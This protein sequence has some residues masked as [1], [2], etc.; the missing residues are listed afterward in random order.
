MGEIAEARVELELLEKQ[1]QQ[2]VDQ[3]HHVRTAVQK[4]KMKLEQLV[5]KISPP[6][7]RLPAEILLLIFKLSVHSSVLGLTAVS[8][9]WRSMVLQCP[10]LWS[11]IEVTPSWCQSFV[12]L[13]VTRSSEYPL[14]IDIHE[15]KEGESHRRLLAML[16][17]LV[18]CADHWRSLVIR[19][20]VSSSHLSRSL[21]KIYHRKSYPSLTHVSIKNIPQSLHGTAKLGHFYAGSCPCLEHLELG[22]A[23]EDSSGFEVPPSLTSLAFG[24]GDNGPSSILPR[25]S[26]QKLTTLSLSGSASGVHID[27]RSISLP[28][29]KNFTCKAYKGNVLVQAIVAPKL[30]YFEYS[31]PGWDFVLGGDFELTDP[32]T[33]YLCL[34]QLA[35]RCGSEAVHFMF[36]AARHIDLGDPEV[37]F[38]AFPSGVGSINRAPDHWPHLES[39]TVRGLAD[40]FLQLLDGLVVWLNVRQTMGLP[41]L[42]V[43]FAFWYG[44][45]EDGSIISALYE[46]LHEITILEWINV[47]LGPGI[48]FSGRTDELLRLVCAF[49]RRQ[50]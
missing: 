46:K 7:N 33:G 14:E 36:P 1:E 2:L 12:K 9:C 23:F 30:D 31:P 16:D 35:T 4:Q 27:P 5:K 26:L 32:H 47:P 22:A 39:L 18:A 25:L 49:Y 10:V 41:R 40:D 44:H 50:N 29:L 38:L 17:V 8:H 45:Y 42:L 21:K 3:L 34:S 43:R 11:A 6:I 28:L 15:W 37:A 13:H 19:A 24:L 48:V 20:D